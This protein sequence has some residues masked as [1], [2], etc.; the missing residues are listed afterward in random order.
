VEHFKLGA[1]DIN[2]CYGLA[3]IWAEKNGHQAVVTWIYQ[4]LTAKPRAPATIIAG[5]VAAKV[6]MVWPAT[7][8]DKPSINDLLFYKATARFEYQG[9]NWNVMADSVDPIGRLKE[10]LEGHPWIITVTEIQVPIF[11][12]GLLSDEHRAVLELLGEDYVRWYP[13]ERSESVEVLGS[14]F[15]EAREHVGSV[16]RNLKHVTRTIKPALLEYYA[17][18]LPAAVALLAPV[19]G[20]RYDPVTENG[21]T[22]FVAAQPSTA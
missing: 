11:A 21:R 7:D 16:A 20:V 10:H 15:Q 13:T 14:A 2:A 19:F 22:I 3:R 8:D 12:G 17:D 6:P 4:F 9:Q 5:L 18:K 1:T